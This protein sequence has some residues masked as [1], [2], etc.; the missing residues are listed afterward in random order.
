MAVKQKEM[1]SAPASFRGPAA[2]LLL[3]W[4]IFAGPVGVALDEMLSYAIVQHSCS[5]D[6]HSL[7]HFYTGV[8]ILSS[9]SGFAAAFWC[10][11]RLPPLN[12]EDGSTAGRSRWMAI[13]GLAASAVF[14]LAIIALSIPKW[15]MGPCDQ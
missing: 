7:L 4:G 6:H 5:T 1:S 10:Y 15:A 2:S 8:G 11:R 14:I 9:L 13:Y 12:L 3:W